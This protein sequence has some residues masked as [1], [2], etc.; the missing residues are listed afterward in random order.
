MIAHRLADVGLRAG[1]SMAGSRDE[2]VTLTMKVGQSGRRTTQVT[3][4][5]P[6]ALADPLHPGQSLVAWI[7]RAM[8]PPPRHIHACL[9]EIIPATMIVAVNLVR[10]EIMRVLDAAIAIMTAAT[11]II[12]IA[13]IDGSGAPMSREVIVGGTETSLGCGHSPVGS[14]MIAIVMANECRTMAWTTRID[15]TTVILHL[16]LIHI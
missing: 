8:R 13:N 14:M 3:Q 16:S 10:G 7:M 6:D 11:V 12:A 4:D 2:V 5:G 15:H 9:Q 1:T